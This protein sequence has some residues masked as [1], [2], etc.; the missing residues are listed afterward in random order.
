MNLPQVITNIEHFFMRVGTARIAA[1][2]GIHQLTVERWRKRG[3]PWKY[4]EKLIDLYDLDSGTLHTIN[5]EIATRR[6]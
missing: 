6:K 5:K 3:I 4:W 1:D 2:L